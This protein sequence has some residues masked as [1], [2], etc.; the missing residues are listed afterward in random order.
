[1]LPFSN[2]FPGNRYELAEEG[3]GTFRAGAELRVELAPDHEGMGIQLS[4]FDQ[5][6]VGG[7]AAEDHPVTLQQLPIVIV[8]FEPVAVSFLHDVAVVG[9][10]CPGVGNGLAGVSAQAHGATHVGHGLLAGHEIY[11]RLSCLDVELG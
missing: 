9:P 4:Y 8:D 10:L 3:M 7:E 6:A 1:M 5:F 2:Y 11:D